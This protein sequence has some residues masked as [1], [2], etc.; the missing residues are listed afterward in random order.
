MTTDN[1]SPIV[2]LRNR[3]VRLYS[4]LFLHHMGS[5]GDG[6]VQGDASGDE[7][8][9]APLW[10][11][12]HSAPYLHDGSAL[13]YQEAIEQ[14]DGEAKASRVRYLRLSKIERDNLNE[15]LDSI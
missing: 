5:L 2:A 8:R 10:G 12:K 7:M 6:V 9:T 3:E 15:F 14:H 13:S 1:R 11:L 4:D